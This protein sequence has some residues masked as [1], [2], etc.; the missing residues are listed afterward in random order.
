MSAAGQSEKKI[1]NA[2]TITGIAFGLWLGRL[3]FMLA[4]IPGA[5]FKNLTILLAAFALLGC[6][7]AF[8]ERIHGA[9]WLLFF[10]SSLCAV[11][12]IVH[13]AMENEVIYSSVQIIINSF[14]GLWLVYLLLRLHFD[15]QKL[16]HLISVIVVV[17]AAGLVYWTLRSP[18]FGFDVAKQRLYPCGID[19]NEYCMYAC[20]AIFSG[21]WAYFEKKSMVLLMALLLLSAAAVLTVSRSGYLGLV[22]ALVLARYF[23]V[24]SHRRGGSGII[25]FLL[26]GAFVVGSAVLVMQQMDYSEAFNRLDFEGDEA[27]G[28]IRRYSSGRFDIW[29]SYW[30]SIGYSPWLGYLSPEHITTTL[31][32]YEISS[33]KL[34]MPHNIVLG[35]LVFYGVP[36][37]VFACTVIIAIGLM[38]FGVSRKRGGENACLVASGY[39]GFVMTSLALSHDISVLLAL[40]V[41]MLGKFQQYADEAA[42]EAGQPEADHGASAVPPLLP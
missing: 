21:F 34:Y 32:P 6:R 23:S 19:P 25:G 20:F 31:I 42:A 10:L 4:N 24:R 22:S 30:E 15:R 38:L 8:K 41:L 36:V 12:K 3:D 1:I 11:V 16:A 5:S 37:G 39:V 18:D 29:Q 28:E 27:Q 13:F 33:G 14:L 35:Y 9:F 2:L 7:A 26:I 17:F 40:F